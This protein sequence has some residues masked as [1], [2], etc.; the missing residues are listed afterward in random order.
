MGKQIAVRGHEVKSFAFKMDAPPDDEGNFTGYAAVFNNVDKGN[1]VIDPGATTKTLQETPDVPVFWVHEYELVPIG[2]GRLSP[3]PKGKGVRIEGKLF[4]DTSELAR[5]VF[6]AMKAGAI[7]GLS[8][9]YETVKRTFKNGVRHLQEIAIGEVSLCPFPMNPLAEVDSVKAQKWLGQYSSTE[10]VDCVLS[11]IDTATDYLASELQEGDAG[12]VGRL[13]QIIPLLLECLQSEI[14]DLPVDLADDAAFD[15][16]DDSDIGVSV[17]VE[18]MRAP[19]ELQIKKLQALLERE[20]GKSTR[21]LKRAANEENVE[22]DD[23]TLRAFADLAS[24]LT[25]K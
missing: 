17:Y 11:L 22:P 12:D 23:S 13:N 21:Q 10:S 20:P 18:Q 2:M 7:R 1:D 6:G 25:S 3:D 24:A 9:G 19:I 14:D 5:E 8:I 4:L 15:A 16:D